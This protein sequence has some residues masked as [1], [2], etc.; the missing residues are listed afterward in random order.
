M[1]SF[2]KLLWSVPIDQWLDPK[3]PFTA[4]PL[5]FLGLVFSLC[6]GAIWV[7]RIIRAQTKL[8]S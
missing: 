8:E 7:K 2:L 4:V 1:L 6:V 5:A 3:N